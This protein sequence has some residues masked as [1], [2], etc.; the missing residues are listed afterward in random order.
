VNETFAF[1]VRWFPHILAAVVGA[2][3]GVLFAHFMTKFVVHRARSWLLDRPL[4][5]ERD[6][7]FDREYARPTK[8]EGGEEIRSGASL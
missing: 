5:E 4:Q 8:T 6:P 1:L 2:V 3:V 7:Y